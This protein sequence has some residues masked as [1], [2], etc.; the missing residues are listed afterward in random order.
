MTIIVT[1]RNIK[2]ENFLWKTENW[3]MGQRPLSPSYNMPLFSLGVE[4]AM[5]FGTL[6]AVTVMAMKSPHKI[7]KIWVK[8]KVQ[9]R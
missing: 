9:G 2:M 5:L 6:K 7:G 8:F 4:Q 1:D 3:V